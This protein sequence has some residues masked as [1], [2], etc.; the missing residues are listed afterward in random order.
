MKTYKRATSA[1]K[2]KYNGKLEGIA[3]FQM[4]LADQAQTEGWANKST[5]DIINIPRDGVDPN[6]GMVNLIKQHT[7][8]LIATLTT[9]ETNNLIGNTVTRKMQNNEN[10]KKCLLETITKDCI[11][12]INIKES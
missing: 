5:G 11:V 9:W 3:V 2:D 1:L 10:M 6:N 8:I 4:Q 7:Q 12:D